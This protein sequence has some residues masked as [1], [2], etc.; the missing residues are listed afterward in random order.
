MNSQEVFK[1]GAELAIE[2]SRSG[3]KAES[4]VGAMFSV[5][6]EEP[7]VGPSAG[8]AADRERTHD[9]ANDPVTPRAVD[10]S[11]K[12]QVDTVPL[13]ADPIGVHTSLNLSRQLG[14]EVELQDEFSSVMLAPSLCQASPIGKPLF[15]VKDKLSQGA[16]DMRQQFHK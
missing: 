8:F 11:R 9:V 10:A 4:D 16:R 6:N 1:C 15:E 5:A 13:R 14:G 12:E 2:A 3:A 7:L